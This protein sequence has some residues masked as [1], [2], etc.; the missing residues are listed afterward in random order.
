MPA[1][2]IE[3]SCPNGS[4]SANFGHE[5]L[6]GFVSI[7][8]RFLECMWLQQNALGS[9]HNDCDRRPGVRGL[10]GKGLSY[11]DA[12]QALLTLNLSHKRLRVTFP[13]SE[14]DLTA[15]LCIGRRFFHS[16]RSMSFVTG[17][18]LWQLL[19]HESGMSC[20]LGFGPIW[21]TNPSGTT[22]CMDRQ[23]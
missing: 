19:P 21:P 9:D 12:W 22:T 13:P 5:G 6:V 8:A 4:S 1:L 16:A 23:I 11:L 17:S 15:N 2:Q 14:K 18:E 10:Q 3:A 7:W 20:V